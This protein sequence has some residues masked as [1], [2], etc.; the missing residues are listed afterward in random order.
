MT[1]SNASA[2]SE[3]DFSPADD[4]IFEKNGAKNNFNKFDQSSINVPPTFQT[5]A[6]T[7]RQFLKRKK[8]RE[9]ER[10]MKK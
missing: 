8:E 10:N 2:E 5:T 3:L 4:V 6:T 9:R 7:E 1:L